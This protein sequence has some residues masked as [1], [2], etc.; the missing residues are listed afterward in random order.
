MNSK[1]GL[2][3]WQHNMLSSLKILDGMSSVVCLK[4]LVVEVKN[5]GETCAIDNK[6]DCKACP[7][8]SDE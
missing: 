3:D 4:G 2:R 6:S 5:K 1:T 8:I 7:V